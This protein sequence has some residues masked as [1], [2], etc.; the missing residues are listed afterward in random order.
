MKYVFKWKL[1]LPLV[2]LF[3]IAS[4]VVPL[5]G[6]FTRVYAAGTLITQDQAL[7]QT[8]LSNHHIV[9]AKSHPGGKTD[10]VYCTGKVDH[11]TAYCM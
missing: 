9:L 3:L 10:G 2:P 5:T 11:A 6:T 1:I 8:I 4:V 7:A